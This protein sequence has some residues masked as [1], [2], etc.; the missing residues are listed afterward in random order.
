MES[1]IRASR[2]SEQEDRAD[3]APRVGAIV[4]KDG[5]IL[6]ECYRGQAGPGAHAEYSVLRQLEGQDLP[7]ASLYTTLEP[8][9]ERSA[10]NHRRLT[11][12]RTAENS[13]WSP[14][15]EPS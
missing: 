4:V 12:S 8:C 1:A 9:T 13:W 7:G 14:P 6:A 2:R 10:E 15:T 3:P 11:S 5:R